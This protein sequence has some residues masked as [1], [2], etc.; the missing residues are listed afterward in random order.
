[1]LERVSIKTM[2]NTIDFKHNFFFLMYIVHTTLIVIFQKFTI[3]L[4][5]FICFLFA[6]ISYVHT[7]RNIFFLTT[8][9]KMWVGSILICNGFI[10]LFFLI[11]TYPLFLVTR[12]KISEIRKKSKEELLKQVKDLRKELLNLR[13]SKVTSQSAPSLSK[14]YELIKMVI[15]SS[16]LDVLLVRVL[17]AY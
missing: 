16:F 10:Y 11:L 7:Q 12:V 8:I 9:F 6:V 13:F 14:M 5:I 2:K 1:M 4:V 15:F 3:F 17:L